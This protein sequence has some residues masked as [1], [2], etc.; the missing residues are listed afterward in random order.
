M[1]GVFSTALRLPCPR[2]LLCGTSGGGAGHVATEVQID[3]AYAEPCDTVDG[4]AGHIA[5]EAPAASTTTGYMD[6][7]PGD[8]CV[9]LSTPSMCDGGIVLPT[10]GNHCD[11]LCFYLMR[12]RVSVLLRTSSV[13]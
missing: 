12:A 4:G 1:R 2:R 9:R 7:H 3:G 11:V 5:T 8:A 10:H 13:A 6:V